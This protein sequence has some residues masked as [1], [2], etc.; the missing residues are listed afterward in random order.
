[1]TALAAWVLRRFFKPA[2]CMLRMLAA[3]GAV[4]GVRRHEGQHGHAPGQA[5]GLRHH[6]EENGFIALPPGWGR[7]SCANALPAKRCTSTSVTSR[8]GLEGLALGQI[9]PFSAIR[10]WPEKT[11]SLVDSP[12]PASA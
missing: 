12:S 7:W 5:G 10:Q 3:R 11:M 2:A 9:W 1:M 4:P 6:V 8:P